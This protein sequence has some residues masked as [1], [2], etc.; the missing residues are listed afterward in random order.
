MALLRISSDAHLD[1]EKI[2]LRIAADD[3]EA[4]DRLTDAI[5][6][7]YKRLARDPYLGRLR[8]ELSPRLRSWVQSNRVI[9]YTATDEVVEIVRVLHGARNLPPLFE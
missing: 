6:E 4:A 5:L 1:L 7:D 2:W 8:S 3:I 9:F